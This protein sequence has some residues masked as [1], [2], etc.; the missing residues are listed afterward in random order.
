MMAFTAFRCRE[1]ARGEDHG[2]D[3][4]ERHQRMVV[5]GDARQRRARLALA[6][7]AQCSTL[8]GGMAVEFGTA[9]R[10]HAVEIAVSRA[11]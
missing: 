8:P 9:E 7:G 11:T 5:I 2:V 10:L 3:L 1:W 4:V 6:A